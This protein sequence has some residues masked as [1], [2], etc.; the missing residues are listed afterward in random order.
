MILLR[1][2]SAGL[3]HEGQCLVQGVGGRLAD[4]AHVADLIVPDEVLH[5]GDGASPRDRD[6]GAR[7]RRA[8]RPRL[9]GEAVGR[10][11]APRLQVLRGL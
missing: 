6:A 2:P 7:Q 9:D 4:E 3:A 1:Q 5:L 8:V 10:L 11:P